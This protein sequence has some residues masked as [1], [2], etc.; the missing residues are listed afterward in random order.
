MRKYKDDIKTIL[1]VLVF[2][3]I[4]LSISTIDNPIVSIMF[5]GLWIGY[6]IYNLYSKFQYRKGNANYILFPTV[7]DQYS[8][9]TSVILGLIVCVLSVVAIVWT[10]NFRHYAA[11][12]ILV[13]MLVFCNG[14]FDLPKGML[15][16]EGN[17]MTIAGLDG[18]IDIRQVKELNIYNDRIVITNIYN[19][20]QRLGNLEIDV[21]S[22]QRIDNYILNNKKENDLKTINNVC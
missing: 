22:A 5:L 17:E 13:G 8:K 12:G 4:Y 21:V 19:E 14:I 15:K 2:G 1:Q 3:I 18:K 7:N 9:V 20:N 16:I 11:L 10:D 6:L